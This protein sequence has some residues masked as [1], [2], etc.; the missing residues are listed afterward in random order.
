MALTN[1]DRVGK[2]LDLLNKGLLPFIERE[3]KAVHGEKLQEAVQQ[4][5][6]DIPAGKGK[7]SVHLDTQAILNVMWD[8]WNVVFKNTLGHSERSIVSE[9]KDIC[10]RWAHQETFSTDDAYRAI[11]N[12]TRLLI[13]VSAPEAE[14]AEA[15]KQELLRIRFDEQ[16]RKQS[17]KMAALPV[18]G[19]P[20]S[21]LKAWREIVTP[22]PDVASGRYQ[23]AE[24]AADLWQVYRNEGGD[25]YKHPAEFFRRTF[26]T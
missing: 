18:S 8:Q 16:A 24:F 6:R 5:I 15:Q 21:G 12:V 9:L 4:S 1:H 13:S 25:E 14:E 10:N 22:H 20:S 17:R 11:D 3:M 2:S 26:L 7:K 19:A 23:Q